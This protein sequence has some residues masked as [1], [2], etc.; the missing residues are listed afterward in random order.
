MTNGDGSQ[1]SDRWEPSPLVI[2]EIYESRVY[3]Y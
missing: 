2:K 3:I 1:W